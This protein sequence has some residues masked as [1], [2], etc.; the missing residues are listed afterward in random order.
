MA[1]MAKAWGS[2]LTRSPTASSTRG[3]QTDARGKEA[4]VEDGVIVDECLRVLIVAGD[5]SDCMAT[6]E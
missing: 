1:Q 2:H 3:D 5:I 4:A 6:I